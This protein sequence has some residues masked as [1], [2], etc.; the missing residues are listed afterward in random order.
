MQILQ[1]YYVVQKETYN[2]YEEGLRTIANS[3]WRITCA[4]FRTSFFHHV[5][6]ELVWKTFLTE[7]PFTDRSAMYRIPLELVK[8]R[9]LHN[10]NVFFFEFAFD[11]LKIPPIAK[12]DFLLR[13]TFIV[14]DFD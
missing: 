9:K 12:H 2:T 8:N 6:V 3:R 5:L 11:F 10:Q 4:T 13:T 7:H 14:E 1:N